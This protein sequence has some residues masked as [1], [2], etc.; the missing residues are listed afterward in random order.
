MLEL[1][2][3][4][5]GMI[6]VAALPGTPVY[7]GK[8]EPI[9][10]SAIREAE[11]Y[12][13]AGIDIIEVENM[14]DTPYLNR[15]VGP[16]ITAAMT[17]LTYEVKRASGLPVGVQV[18]AGANREAIA[19][20]FVSGADF[21]RAEGFVFSHVAD[22]GLM[23]GS[24]AELLRYRKAIGAENVAVFTDIQKKHSSHA[25]TSDI[26]IDTYAQAAEFFRADGVIVTGKATGD[27]ADL[28]E[29]RCTKAAV[30]IPVL[31]G[32]GVTFE[33]VEPY[34]QY[35]DGLIVGSWFKVDGNWENPPDPD[36]VSRFME[37]VRKFR[38]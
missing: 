8:F 11:I 36:R 21:I 4:I 7:G 22:E 9:L 25:I 14:H 19:A 34:L 1:K 31:I 6:H 2:K 30:K 5:V 15:N 35:A 32:S 20:A 27:P 37:K 33:N 28:E 24:A 23:N 12:R 13:D 38:G 10:E 16:E 29:L 17:L 18:L 26:A 3:S